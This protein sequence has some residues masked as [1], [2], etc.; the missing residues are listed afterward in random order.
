[1]PIVGGA[2]RAHDRIRISPTALFGGALSN[3]LCCNT[4]KFYET[5]QPRAKYGS[6]LCHHR[7]RHDLAGK[8]LSCV[9]CQ[10]NPL[11]GALIQGIP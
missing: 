4:K 10:N 3:L 11:S 1:M 2:A 8:E 6:A 7:R 5:S 9:A